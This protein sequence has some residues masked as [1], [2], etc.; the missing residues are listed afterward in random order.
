MA[1]LGLQTLLAEGRLRRHQSSPEEV[2]DMLR[3]VD[4]ELAEAESAGADGR[5]PLGWNPVRTLA[6]IALHAAGYAWARGGFK[7]M[8]LVIELLPEITG[9]AGERIVEMLRKY[10]YSE[11]VAASGLAASN[12]AYRVHQGFLEEVKAGLEL[13]SE[14]KA[15]R[16]D[17]LAWLKANRPALVPEEIK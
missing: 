11:D 14:A 16:R 3:L 12:L 5:L 8:W 9:G 15:L 10:V 4:R 17:L 13:L 6:T 1:L 2:A 7:E